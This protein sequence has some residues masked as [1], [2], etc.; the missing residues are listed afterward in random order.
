M[1]LVDFSTPEKKDNFPF[2]EQHEQ[3]YVLTSKRI[4]Q[5]QGVQNNTFRVY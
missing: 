2:E 1:G 3:S 5:I 4:N